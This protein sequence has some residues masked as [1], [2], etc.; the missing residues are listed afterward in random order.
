MHQGGAPDS[1]ALGSTQTFFSY[2]EVMEITNGFSRQNVIGEGGFGYV[3]K[4]R[5]PDG[6]EVAVKQLKAGSGQGEREFRAEVEIISRVHHRYLVSLV[7]YC[8]SEQQRLLIYEFVPNKTLEHHLH[9]KGNFSCFLTLSTIIRLSCHDS[10]YHIGICCQ[11]K[12][13]RCWIGQKDSRLL[14][15]LRR[16]W[17]IY[18]KIV[19]I[20]SC[21]IITIVLVLNEKKK[22][23]S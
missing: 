20:F 16:V 13:C 21:I 18:M 14:W 7:G 4:G 9:G 10:Y 8:I 6:R 11:V 5:L 22:N 3:Y 19:C 12:E 23:L 17:H 1:S 15:G 2:E